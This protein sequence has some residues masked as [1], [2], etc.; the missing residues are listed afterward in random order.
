MVEGHLEVEGDTFKNHPITLMA[1]PT[2]PTPATNGS[3]SSSS[4]SYARLKTA[5]GT[6]LMIGL[7]APDHLGYDNQPFFDWLHAL[8]ANINTFYNKVL[9]VGGNVF[10]NC[11]MTQPPVK[12]ALLS[13]LWNAASEVKWQTGS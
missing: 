3:T 10:K 12:K 6:S 8:P 7:S 4:H 9:S 13:G 2:S 5:K 1:T 11:T